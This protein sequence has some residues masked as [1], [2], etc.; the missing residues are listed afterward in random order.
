MKNIYHSKNI[1]ILDLRKKTNLNYFVIIIYTD[2]LET[3]SS[4]FHKNIIYP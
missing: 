3:G 4:L 1:K 2:A